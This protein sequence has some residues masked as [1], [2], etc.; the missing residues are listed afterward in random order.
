MTERYIRIRSGWLGFA[1]AEERVETLSGDL[2]WQRIRHA[3]FL[4]QPLPPLPPSKDA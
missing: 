2:I 1:I 4:C 3:V